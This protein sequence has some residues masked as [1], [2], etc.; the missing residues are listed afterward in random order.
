MIDVLRR[1]RSRHEF[2][3]VMHSF[4]G[5]SSQADELLEMGMYVSFA[6]MLT[7]KKSEQL[8][9]TA[10]RIPLERLLVETDS[11]YLSPEPYRGKR[12]NEPARVI[13]TA[14]TLAGIMGIGVAELAERT[15]QNAHRLFH[16]M[17][18]E[19]LAL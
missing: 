13:H 18:D 17:S 16:K 2:T 3:A 8:R 10:S 9:E 7:F 15:T 11:P 1:F 5:E 19:L 4:A 14:S 12:P 6:G